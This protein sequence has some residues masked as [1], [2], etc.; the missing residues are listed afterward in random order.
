[1]AKPRIFVSSTFFDLRQVRSDLDRF[2]KDM[3]YEPVLNEMGNI[4]YGKDDKLEEYC[5]KEIS[6][7]DILVAIVGGRFG[8]ESQNNHYSI[9]QME[10]RTAFEQNKQVYIFIEK[11]V[12]AEYQTYLINKRNLDIKY[13]F[14]DNIKIYQFIEYIES[15]PN[16]NNIYGFET[17]YD[18]IH[19]LQEQW[20][21]LFQRF[22]SEQSRFKEI[23][24]IKGIENTAKTLNQLVD[25]LTEERKDKDRAIQDILLSNHPAMEQVRRILNVGYRVY[26][27][28]KEELTQWLSARSYRLNEIDE[29]LDEIV[30]EDYFEYSNTDNRLSKKYILRIQKQIFNDDGKLKVYTNFEWREEFITLTVNDLSV[31]VDD[32]DDLPF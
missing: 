13:K 16:N 25:F 2:I 9:S 3:G 6:S 31:V 23:N 28:S 4:P 7:I 20:S 8:S 32:D 22:L 24:L 1:M 29:L 30:D 14:A 19:Y 10:F 17:S 11:N 5:Y 27:T 18:I 15:L 26:F 21:G 12:H